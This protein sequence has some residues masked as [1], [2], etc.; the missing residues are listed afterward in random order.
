M[1]RILAI[2]IIIVGATGGYL[3]YR[4]VGCISGTCAITSNPFT[5]T[6]YG[7]LFGFIVAASLP[8]ASAPK[9]SDASSQNELGEMRE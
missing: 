5:S 4:F 3:Y 9:E 6:L 8:L 2:A 7:A 1:K